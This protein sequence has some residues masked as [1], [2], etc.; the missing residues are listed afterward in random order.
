MNTI[1]LSDS[2]VEMLLNYT[3]ERR[4]NNF[5]FDEFRITHKPDGPGKDIHKI[6][7]IDG[8]IYVM[9]RAIFY[10]TTYNWIDCEYSF[11]YDEN[12]TITFIDKPQGELYDKLSEWT[13]SSKEIDIKDAM[14]H[15]ESVAVLICNLMQYIMNESYKRQIIYRD[16]PTSKVSKETSITYKDKKRNDS[17]IKTEFLLKDIIHYVSHNKRKFKITCECWGVRGHFRRYKS[18]KVVWISAYEKGEKRNTG[19]NFSGKTYKI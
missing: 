1:M 18:G 4:F 8:I 15:F 5:I 13:K 6:K 2:D 17:V 12:S 16:T 9:Q 14:D 11:T 7:I 19:V 3:Y 10:D